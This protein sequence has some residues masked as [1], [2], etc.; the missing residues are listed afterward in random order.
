MS[1]TKRRR[2]ERIVPDICKSIISR[3]YCM[4]IHDFQACGN[5][6]GENRLWSWERWKLEE[7]VGDHELL[8]AVCCSQ[9]HWEVRS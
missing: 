6:F 2:L 8:A 1:N 9:Q 5:V 4:V 7:V 3:R